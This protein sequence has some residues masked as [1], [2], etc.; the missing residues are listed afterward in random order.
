[1]AKSKKY[2]MEHEGVE[3]ELRRSDVDFG[4][5]WTVESEDWIMGPYDLKRHA[6]EFAHFAID[7]Q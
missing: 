1:M 7:Q 3:F 6:L 2:Q 4:P 5:K